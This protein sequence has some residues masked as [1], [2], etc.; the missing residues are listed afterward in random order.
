MK[1]NKKTKKPLPARD[2]DYEILL[3]QGSK[4]RCA[5]LRLE[6]LQSWSDKFAV[7]GCGGT[8]RFASMPTFFPLHL[9]TD[10]EEVPVYVG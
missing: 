1:K 10:A 2:N 5:S 9:F 4:V 3:A 7:S 6:A 8:V